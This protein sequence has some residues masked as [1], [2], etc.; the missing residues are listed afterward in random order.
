MPGKSVIRDVIGFVLYCSY[1]CGSGL[2]SSHCSASGCQCSGFRVQCGQ[3]E[4]S[5]DTSSLG[6]QTLNPE[7]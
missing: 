3:Y 2:F 6:T 4:A 5:C 1:L 7:P